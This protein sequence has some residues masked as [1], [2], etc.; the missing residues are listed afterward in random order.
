MNPRRRNW[1]VKRKLCKSL[2]SEV[3]TVEGGKRMESG[4]S[5][6]S[7]AGRQISQSV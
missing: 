3:G 4:L 7:A 5:H 6:V 2:S 1:L